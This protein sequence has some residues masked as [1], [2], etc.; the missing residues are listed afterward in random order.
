[1][2]VGR[3]TADLAEVKGSLVRSMAVTVSEHG[4]RQAVLGRVSEATAAL[5]RD[6]PLPTMWVDARAYNEILQALYE[7]E[8]AE[9][10]R[11]LNR[12][13]VERGLAPLLRATAQGMLRVFG[14]SPATVLSRLGRLSAATSRGV[15]TRYALST[16]TSGS[17]EIELPALRDVPIG[18]FVA[19]G[20]GI[21]LVF[22]LCGVSGTI[23]EPTWIDEQRRNAMRFAV[24]WLAA[25]R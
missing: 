20:G 12:E 8:G 13:A 1:M 15:V 6:P 11:H 7:I 25:R 10:L 2:S 3:T 21:K 24:A 17:L 23:G 19:S 14:T 18:A 4:L 16:P 5:L 9:R 22:E